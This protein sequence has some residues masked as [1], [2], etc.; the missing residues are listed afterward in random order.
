[1]SVEGVL[2]YRLLGSHPAA[3]GRYLTIGFPGETTLVDTILQQLV[4]EHHIN[5]SAFK[6]QVTR[7]S[8]TLGRSS[9]SVQKP[10]RD[11]DGEPAS[12]ADEEQGTVLQLG[13][14]LRSY[15]KL[16]IM[17]SKR[18]IADEQDAAVAR[19]DAEVRT[20]IQ[21]MEKQL[22]MAAPSGA[23]VSGG[24][25]PPASGASGLGVCDPL[26]L[27]R[28]AHVA[29]KGFPIKPQKRS[30]LTDLDDPTNDHI[31][32][33]CDLGAYAELL[34]ACCSFPVCFGCLEAAGAMTM[35][36][37]ECPVCGRMG[38][39]TSTSLPP[40]PSTASESKPSIMNAAKADPRQA[41]SAG[42]PLYKRERSGERSGGCAT[43]SPPPLI[44][45]EMLRLEEELRRSLDQCLSFLDVPD[46]LTPAQ[47]AKRV[48]SVAMTALDEGVS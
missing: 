11:G 33:L 7:L 27:E 22:Y 47:R 44:T 48:Q 40:T 26:S 32:V 16:A 43:G 10:T 12:S 1:M 42:R 37:G 35:R 46:P 30:T 24:R 19:R 5:L 6:L 20:R 39:G 13:D 9:G 36:D 41:G 17:V 2:Q 21:E 28:A 29:N 15:D 31:C 25:L 45:A 34:T 14:T 23:N 4:K 38:S 18:G 8:S 3:S